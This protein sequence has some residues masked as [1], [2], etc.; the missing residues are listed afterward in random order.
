MLKSLNNDPGAIPDILMILY[1]VIAAI[2]VPLIFFI[3][4]EAIL[5]MYDEITR[6]SYSEHK[7]SITIV[8]DENSPK[9]ERLFPD[10][11]YVDEQKRSLID[12]INN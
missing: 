6:R 4:K 12:N 10:N 5:I 3:G 2:H 11:F 7:E 8:I 9:F 1:L